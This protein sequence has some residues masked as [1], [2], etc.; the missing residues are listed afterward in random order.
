MNNNSLEELF[1]QIEGLVK[2]LE[3]P[4]IAIEE[5]F[6]KYKQGMDLL[7]T[8]NEKIDGIEKQVN[9]IAESGEQSDE[10]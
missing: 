7:K 6:S 4:D 1:E 5:A 8:C 10:L 2:D 3:N 9:E